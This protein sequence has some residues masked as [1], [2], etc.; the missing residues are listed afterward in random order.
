MAFIF[1]TGSEQ[2]D[3][4]DK[5]KQGEEVSWS[6]SRYLI[7]IDSGALIL[8]WLSQREQPRVRG[9]YGWGI[10]TENAKEDKEGWFRIRL[11]C[12]ERWD[13]Y[14]ADKA[15]IKASDILNLPAWKYHPLKID[16]V[17]SNFLVSV[18]QL[19]E[20]CRYIMKVF[21][22]SEFRE[23]VDT[24]MGGK[25]LNPNSFKPKHL[26]ATEAFLFQTESEQWDLRK[27]KEGEEK[28]LSWLLSLYQ[29]P[30]DRGA[31]FLLWLS[32]GKQPTRVRGLYGWGIT[33]ENSKED[34]QG[35]LHI[36]LKCVERWDSHTADKAPI[37]ASDILNLPAWKDHRLKTD[38]E[39]SHFP[40]SVEQLRELCDCIMDIFP[41]SQFREAIDTEMRR[42]RL[43]PNLFEHKSLV[44]KE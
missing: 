20:L 18:E 10:T 21:P 6:L 13:S 3:L 25:R 30:I 8:L 41:D 43:D 12:V 5:L 26:V 40:V 38:F 35:K 2:W 1:Q 37:E 15:P 44:A 31:L 23:A 14:T 29:E 42:E 22:D 34:K 39:W 17:G 11:K 33:T 27:L 4:R 32:Q 9:L 24:E 36:L 7:L 19:R 28:D 16:F